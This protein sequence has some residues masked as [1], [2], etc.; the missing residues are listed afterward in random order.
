LVAEYHAYAAVRR[1]E[2]VV[3]RSRS[4][5][6][7]CG[8]ASCRAGYRVIG[9][10]PPLV[11]VT[12]YSDS[13]DAWAPSF[14]DLLAH[15]HRILALDNEGIGRTTLRAGPLTISRMGD[16]VGDFIG[17]LHLGHTDV[18]G[19]SMGGYIVQALAV[20]HP[21][22]V[23]RI[24]LCATL[25]GDGTARASSVPVRTSPPFANLLPAG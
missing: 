2:I 16:D 23:R 15:D 18:L 9:T 11:L 19:W 5:I 22:S 8:A 6:P 21:G 12:G 17:A 1:A 10:G 4:R 25:P 7:T 24:I 20:R 13:I 3:L 14:L